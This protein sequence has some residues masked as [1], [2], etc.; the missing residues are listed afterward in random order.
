MQQGNGYPKIPCTIFRLDTDIQI[1]QSMSDI[2]R[3]GSADMDRTANLVR[4]MEEKRK[5]NAAISSE[6]CFSE[7][8][9][10]DM[11]S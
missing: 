3:T 10:Q 7:D 1:L 2:K 11:Y 4:N 5:Q 6:K 8:S 9:F